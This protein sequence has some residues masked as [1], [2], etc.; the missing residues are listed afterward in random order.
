MGQL[1]MNTGDEEERIGAAE[2]RILGL[3][4]TA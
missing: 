2:T 1:D 3:M 4:S